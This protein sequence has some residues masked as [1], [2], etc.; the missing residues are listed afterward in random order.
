M[1][2]LY[3]GK[4]DNGDLL[5]LRQFPNNK[6]LWG[7]CEYILDKSCTDYDWLV[8]YDDLPPAESE[9]FSKRSESLSC[10]PKNTLLITSEPS[11]IKV[12]GS[13]YIRQF[14]HVLTTQEPWAIKHP[15]AIYSQCGYRWFYGIGEG[16]VKG[17][18]AIEQNKPDKK[19]ALISTVCSNKQQKNTV[20]AQRFIFTQK[21]KKALPELEVF[22]RGVRNLNDKAEAIDSYKYHVVIENFYGKDHWSEKLADTY[23]G[24]ALPFYYGCPNLEQY[25]PEEAFIRIN[26]YDVEKSIKIIRKAIANNEYEKREAHVSAARQKILNDYNFFG[27]IN[28]IIE[29]VHTTDVGTKAQVAISSRRVCRNSSP[30]NFI[31]YFYERYSVKLRHLFSKKVARTK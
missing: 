6:P 3:R 5:W 2:F 18:N 15:D 10:N 23:L 1:K 22:G 17:W 24:H 25:F 26:P 12:Y 4:S 8:V 21:L 19:T 14:N 16:Y 20:H 11:T 31:F 9:R 30:W 13:K 28:K 29:E 7:N 27:V